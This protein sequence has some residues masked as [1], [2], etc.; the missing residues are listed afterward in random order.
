M[1]IEGKTCEKCGS[2]LI[3][4]TERLSKGLVITLIKFVEAIKLKGINE[5]HLQSEIELSK[6]EYNNFQK[7]RYHGLVHHAKLPSGDRKPGYWIMTLNGGRFLRNEI[8]I[9]KDIVVMNNSIVDRGAETVK[10]NDFFAGRDEDYWQTNFKMDIF[11][12]RLI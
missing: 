8:M 4:R 1:E 5:I 3:P 12:G 7:L 9:S 2:A 10:I 6:N 11:Q